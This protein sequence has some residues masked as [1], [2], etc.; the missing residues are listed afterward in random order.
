MSVE[1]R[2]ARLATAI[3]GVEKAQA[4][5]DRDPQNTWYRDVRDRALRDLGEA[6]KAILASL[7]RQE[8]GAVDPEDAERWIS[9]W[10]DHGR[11]TVRRIKQLQEG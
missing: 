4:C 10:M 9:T 2:K 5:L 11:R 8:A 7:S 6:H 3:E 1:G